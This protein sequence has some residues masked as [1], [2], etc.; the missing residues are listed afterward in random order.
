[1]NKHNL[2]KHGLCNHKLYSVWINMKKRCY[3]IN[4]PNYKYYGQ[5]GIK[6]C[7]EWLNDPE[8]FIKWGLENGYEKDLEIDRIDNNGHYEPDNCRFVS[9]SVQLLNRRP[10]NKTGIKYVYESGKKYKINKTINGQTKYF[11]TFET[12]EEAKKVVDNL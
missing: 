9:R 12:L 3:N 8:M 4:T 1:M 6:V 7:K 5:R 2:F 10:F 11:G